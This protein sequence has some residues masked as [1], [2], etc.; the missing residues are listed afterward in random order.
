MFGGGTFDEG[1]NRNLCGGI[2]SSI[3]DFKKKVINLELPSYAPQ[4]SFT[5]LVS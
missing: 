2:L 5:V 4:G 1:W 3:L